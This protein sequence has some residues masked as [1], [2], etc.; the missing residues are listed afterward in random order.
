[1]PGFRVE[2]GTVNAMHAALAQTI[3]HWGPM[4]W[5]YYA[6]VGGAIAYAA[7]RRGRSPL[8]SAIFTPIFGQKTEGWLGSIIDIFA[9]VVTLGGTA[10][11]LGIGALQI[12]RGFEII[13]GIGEVGNGF[14]I[15]A[16]A[17]LTALFVV[18]AVSGIKR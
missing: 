12:S 2:D 7:Y 3:L 10:I 4:A 17:V 6:L 11:S 18:S 9:I 13:T 5:A 8:I 14:I 15:G 1:P 16:I